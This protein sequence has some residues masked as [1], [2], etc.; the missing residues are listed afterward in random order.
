MHAFF[1]VLSVASRAS[2]LGLSLA[3]VSL[4]HVLRARPILDIAR[5]SASL[6]LTYGTWVGTRSRQQMSLERWLQ[7]QTLERTFCWMLEESRSWT[8]E[9]LGG[10][11]PRDFLLSI[12]GVKKQQGLRRSLRV[13]YFFRRFLDLRDC[14]RYQMHYG[15]RPQ[16]FEFKV[17]FECWRLRIY[18]QLS[19]VKL[20]QEVIQI[21]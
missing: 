18:Y 5:T 7:D 6:N 20:V 13:K 10:R 8:S 2:L 4:V 14:R 19:C 17:S 16:G 3:M 11:N 9:I 12:G 15:R 1:P 21:L